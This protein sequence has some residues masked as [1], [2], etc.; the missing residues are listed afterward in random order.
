MIKHIFG[1]IGII[2]LLFAC[3]ETKDTQVVAKKR[4]TTSKLPIYGWTGGVDKLSDEALREKFTDW[5]AKGLDGILVNGG[6]DPAT[7]ERVGKITASLDLELHAWIP[8]MVQ[9]PKEGIDSDWYAV[10]GNG[11][12]ALE[13]PAYVDYYKFLCPNKEGVY[14][15]LEK[16][17]LQVA[18]VKEVTSIH[19]DYIRFPDVILARGLWDKYNLV[20]DKEYPPYD[21]CY[22]STCAKDFKEQSGIDILKEEDPSQI[23]SWKQFRYD[24]ITKIV[25]QLTEKIHQKGKKVTAAVFPGPHSVAKKIVRQ[26]WDKW[27]IDAYYPMLYND[28]YLEKPA[29]IGDMTKEGVTAINNRAPLYSGLFICADPANKAQLK[30]PENHGLVPEELEEAISVSMKNGAA[31]ICLF[32]PDRMTDEHWEILERC[33]L[34]PAKSR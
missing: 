32:T 15:F 2:L 22:C 16:M 28:F 5:K 3:G 30:D 24:L 34:I 10:N 14:D 7:Y 9:A 29:W 8:T 26:E 25:N 23:E 4:P 12:S 21:Y 31:G 19:L 33:L 20:M 27:N 6:Q 17:Y 13:K 11:E 1:W 18:E